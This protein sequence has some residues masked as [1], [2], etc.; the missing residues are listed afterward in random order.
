MKSLAG[1]VAIVT[2]ASRAF[3]AVA[4]AWLVMALLVSCAAA[5]EQAQPE[6][7]ETVSENA[8][9]VSDFV[10]YSLSM[11]L[12]E[13]LS[14]YFV[15]DDIR[16]AAVSCEQGMLLTYAD[17][18]Q[19]GVSSATIPGEEIAGQEE[20]DPLL[21]WLPPNLESHIPST[22]IKV[23]A[24]DTGGKRYHQTLRISLYGINYWMF[25][26]P[27]RNIEALS[28]PSSALYKQGKERTEL[29]PQ[30]PYYAELV[31]FTVQ[32]IADLPYADDAAVMMD[33]GEVA[34]WKDQY[35]WVEL[36]YPEK[37]LAGV[38]VGGNE[39]MELIPYT[40]IL[41]FTSAEFSNA[42]LFYNADE[43]SYSRPVQ[44]ARWADDVRQDVFDKAASGTAE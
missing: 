17:G 14:L 1:T 12:Q 31:D 8:I 44:L 38:F 13:G 26:V 35:D 24:T 42:A 43:E 23:D 6:A 10:R 32:R 40:R 18:F 28:T 4:A 9:I 7:P 15:L 20:D 30:D 37:H 11:S 29:Y 21:H 39:G 25:D 5:N 19:T 2:R 34:A 27:D 16:S 3:A 41:M 22:T 33:N 36:Y